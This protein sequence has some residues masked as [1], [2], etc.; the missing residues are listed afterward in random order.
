[1]SRNS[2]PQKN[3][4][5]EMFLLDNERRLARNTL[6]EEDGLIRGVQRAALDAIL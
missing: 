5:I 1:M 2:I 3:G 4:Q 6:F